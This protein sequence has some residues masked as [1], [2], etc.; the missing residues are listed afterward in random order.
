MT[1]VVFPTPGSRLERW[2]RGGHVPSAI[3]SMVSATARRALHMSAEG[4]CPRPA[5]K[6]LIAA[7]VWEA[8]GA[9][10]GASFVKRGLFTCLPPLGG[11]RRGAVS[12]EDCGGCY[13]MCT[14]DGYSVLMGWLA[15]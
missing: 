13:V 7:M 10:G 15:A 4:W 14:S 3:F 8:S 6:P 5:K 11:G 9:E 12:A 1:V 2:M